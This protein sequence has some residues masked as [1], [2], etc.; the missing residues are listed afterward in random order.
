MYRP[1]PECGLKHQMT[2][3]GPHPED[4]AKDR[5]H[6]ILGPDAKASQKLLVLFDLSGVLCWTPRDGKKLESPLSPIKRPEGPRGHKS[7]LYL[8]PGLADLLRLLERQSANALLEWGFYTTRNFQNAL[9]DIRLLLSHCHRS[10]DE[11]QCKRLSF[12]SRGEKSDDV[13]KSKGPAEFHKLKYCCR[14]RERFFWCF[15]QEDCE[16]DVGS[17]SVYENTGDRRHVFSPDV[18]V[19]AGRK[20]NAVLYVAGNESKFKL[21]KQTQCIL[22]EDFTDDAVGSPN[23]SDNAFAEVLNQINQH[24]VSVF[25]KKS[26]NDAEY[27][28]RRQEIIRAFLTSQCKPIIVQAVLSYLGKSK[29]YKH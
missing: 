11:D 6:T 8:R 15:T 1:C 16:A 21:L 13:G 29:G 18:A 12:Q 26:Q 22:V 5:L 4:A 17:S 24:E 7:W 28:N 20:R 19:K 2:D 23:F 3:P 14:G 27:F 10:L 25:A 9:I